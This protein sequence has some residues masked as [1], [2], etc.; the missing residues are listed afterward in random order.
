M[1]PGK[2]AQRQHPHRPSSSV[3][4]ASA[5][6]KGG[7]KRGHKPIA[8][9]TRREVDNWLMTF[10]RPGVDPTD[11]TKALWDTAEGI[12]VILGNATRPGTAFSPPDK[13]Y[14]DRHF[15]GKPGR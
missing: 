1:K 15:P 3:A 8:E 7:E 5:L 14:F 13:G 4:P 12:I 2:S 9:W 6:T 10:P 11:G